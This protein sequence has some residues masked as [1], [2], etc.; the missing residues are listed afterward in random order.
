MTIVNFEVISKNG[1]IFDRHM[2]MAI[3]HVKVAFVYK[4]LSVVEEE[5]FMYNDNKIPIQEVLKTTMIEINNIIL[6]KNDCNDNDWS[7]EI[8][9]TN[10]ELYS[11]L[12]TIQLM[13]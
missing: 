7:I 5:Y 13:L 2:N 9:T 1:Y 10:K 3:A 6:I 11:K 4:T 8:E 12:N